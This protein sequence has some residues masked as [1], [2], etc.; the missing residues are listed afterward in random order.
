M[1][2]PSIAELLSASGYT[3][4]TGEL[5]D[6]AVDSL[7]A[8]IGAGLDSRDWDAIMAA[9]NPLEASENALMEKGGQTTFFLPVPRIYSLLLEIIDK[10]LTLHCCCP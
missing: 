3:D 1:S 9:E 2:K 5:I 7:Y 8:N 10:S 4:Y 6:R